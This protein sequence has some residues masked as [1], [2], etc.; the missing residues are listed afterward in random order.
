MEK[1]RNIKNSIIYNIGINKKNETTGSWISLN[2]ECIIKEE[3][4][5]SVSLIFRD[6]DSSIEL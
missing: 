6:I 3:K 5:N 4:E 2:S 1:F